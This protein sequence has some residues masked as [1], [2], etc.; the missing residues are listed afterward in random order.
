MKSQSPLKSKI[1]F[2][3]HKSMCRVLN[4][5]RLTCF[6]A[7]EARTAA[8]SWNC[9]DAYR[10]ESGY[11][12][13]IMMKVFTLLFFIKLLQVL[14]QTNIQM[15]SLRRSL[16]TPWGLR[17]GGGIFTL[18]GSFQHSTK[19]PSNKYQIRVS[20]QLSLT[21]LKQ[22]DHGITLCY[23]QPDPVTFLLR[24][25]VCW[26]IPNTLTWTGG[27]FT[28]PQV[29]A[30][31]KANRKTLRYCVFLTMTQALVCATDTVRWRLPGGHLSGIEAGRKDTKRTSTL[32]EV[33]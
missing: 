18:G 27:W 14:R 4:A 31:G 28:Y 19:D 26:F 6:I 23:A 9:S 7:S 13:P 33:F 8:L 15:L 2:L 29:G 3:K 1:I 30:S 20:N 25:L 32:T 12:F 5:R 22:K 11:Q 21:N 24:K 16:G 10:L 17:A